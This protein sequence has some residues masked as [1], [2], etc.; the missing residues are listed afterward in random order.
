MKPV[1]QRE[2]T[3]LAKRIVQTSKDGALVAEY[4]SIGQAAKESGVNRRSISDVLS[5]VQKT[6]GGYIWKYADK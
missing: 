5:G 4:A 6:A 2:N 3:G 1:K